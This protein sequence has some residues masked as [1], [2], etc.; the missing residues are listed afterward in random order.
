MARA[1][2]PEGEFLA[3]ISFDPASSL[4]RPKKVFA[5]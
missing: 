3:V 4:W 1:Y 2:G 5:P